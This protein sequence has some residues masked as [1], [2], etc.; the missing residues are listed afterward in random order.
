MYIHMGFGCNIRD[1]TPS[2]VKKKCFDFSLIRHVTS[3]LLLDVFGKP[4]Q[5][6]NDMMSIKRALQ[7]NSVSEA[8]HIFAE[9]QSVP[10]CCSQLWWIRVK[11]II[12]DSFQVFLVS[13]H[14]YLEEFTILEAA[15][16]NRWC[17]GLLIMITQKTHF[18]SI[19][20]TQSQGCVTENP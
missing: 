10:R 8:F 1:I 7:C 13:S 9:S 18:K 4:S 3:R 17:L 6:W 11:K 15:L 12:M 14:V 19:K 5:K 2:L 20:S 16:E